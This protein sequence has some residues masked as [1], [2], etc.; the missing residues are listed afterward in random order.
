MERFDNQRNK[1]QILYTDFDMNFDADPDTGDIKMLTNREC[2]RSS[3]FRIIALNKMDIPFNT[4]AYTQL[5]ELL[6]EIPS[7]TIEASIS[8]NLAWIIG[9]LEPRVR[10]DDITVTYDEFENKYNVDLTYTIL[11]EQTQDTLKKPLERVR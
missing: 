9:E 11:R 1:G 3:L 5:K 10:V 6:F 8:T 7:H 2:I 4:S